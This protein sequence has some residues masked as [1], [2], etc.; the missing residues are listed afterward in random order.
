MSKD[1]PCVAWTNGD[2]SARPVATRPR[3]RAH[4][5][6]LFAVSTPSSSLP[7]SGRDAANT[8]IPPMI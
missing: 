3:V 5:A 6:E 1:V 4:W 7:S 2:F 8:W